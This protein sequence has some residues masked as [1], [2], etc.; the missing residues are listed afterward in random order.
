MKKYFSMILAAMLVSVFSLTA[1]AVTDTEEPSDVVSLTATA[2]D[3]SVQLKWPKAT[4]DVGVKGYIV[5]YG[6]KSVTK[7]GEKY[8]KNVDVK[9]VL[10]Y[11]VTGLENGKKYYFSVVAY[12]AAGNESVGWSPEA[13]AT[14]NKGSAAPSGEDKDAPQVADAESLY[15]TEVKVVFS[16]EVVLPKVD[17]QDAF[18]IENDDTFE[19]LAVSDAAMDEEDKTNKTVILTTQD[20]G[21]KANYKLTVGIDIEDKAGNPIISGTSD[22]ALFVGTTTEKEADDKD[23][24]GPEIVKVETVDATHI[25]VN[26]NEAVVLSID[27]SENFEIVAKEGGKKLE[28]LG[29]ELGANSE[30]VDDASAVITTSAQ[31]KVNYTVTIVKLKDE[32][33]NPVNSAKNSAV[34]EGKGEATGENPIADIIPPK[35][36]AN[37]LAKSMVKGEKYLVT[38]RWKIPEAN[39]GDVKEQLIYMSTDKG[40]KY[41]Q[42]ASVAPDVTEYKAE[43]LVPGE[44]WFKI[45]QKDAAGNESAGVIS[46]IVLSET[47]PEMLGLLGLSVL[48]GRVVTKRKKK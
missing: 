30:D 19:A 24:K 42:K 48:L 33:G 17:P 5:H 21:E 26:F 43:D 22:T 6:A 41:D 36:V 46:K 16:E 31:E 11:E 32:A 27:P 8:D 25:I 4:D 37:F 44:Y 29:V 10:D 45:T 40:A 18:S 7:K 14:P 9:N 38:L 15:K 47:G 3:K 34:F 13:S 39:I 20:Q 35:D 1:F 23:E 12:D 28:V 2:Q